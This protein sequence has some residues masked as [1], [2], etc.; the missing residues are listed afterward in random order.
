VAETG[1]YAETLQ[2]LP[3]PRADVLAAVQDSFPEV[4]K[5]ARALFLLD[6]SESMAEEE[7][8]VTKLQRA[9]DAIVKALDHFVPGDEV[10]LA[11]FSHIE[12]GPLEPGL[13][14]PVAPVETGKDGIVAKL[15]GLQTMDATPLFEAV[16]RF[17]AEQARDYK[18]TCINTIVLLSDGRNDS[19]HPGDLTGLTDQL[20][21]HNS[22]TPVLVFTLAYGPEAD[23]P[24]LLEI[25][26]ASG[27]HYYDATDA[28]R[29]EEVLGELVTSF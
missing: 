9:K 4:R 11:A 29:L 21:R 18:D 7:Q 15:N 17:A 28:T 1:R 14:S 23:T 19:T 20:K 6:V 8:G 2:P 16:G 13:V 3:L 22:A 12:D 27:A 10:G 26:K 5:R 25:A 24:T